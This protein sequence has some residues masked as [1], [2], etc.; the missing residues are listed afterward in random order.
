[1][2][3]FCAHL[4]SWNGSPYSNLIE[5]CIDRHIHTILLQR[6]YDQLAKVQVR[7]CHRRFPPVL[8]STMHPLRTVVAPRIELLGELDLLGSR[9]I[10][11]KC[12]HQ[13]PTHRRPRIQ[14]VS[15][16]PWP[17][18]VDPALFSTIR[19]IRFRTIYINVIIGVNPP[20]DY[21]HVNSSLAAFWVN[22]LSLGAL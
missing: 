15:R 14:H 21:V 1:M 5:I 3:S 2:V 6:S 4:T 12:C 18:Q 10:D 7:H 11:N 22:S 16:F 13:Y 17:L 9:F 19:L 8:T 20:L